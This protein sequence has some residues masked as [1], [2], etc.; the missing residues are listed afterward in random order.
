MEVC[1]HSL[2]T[3]AIGVVSSQVH[4][5]T[6]LTPG[7][8]SPLYTEQKDG[9][10]QERHKTVLQHTRR[11]TQQVLKQHTSCIYI[12]ILALRS[13]AGHGLL[14]LEVSTSHTMTHHSRQ[15][16]SGRVISS[17]QR[18]LPDN[19]QHSQETNIHA[20]GGI[21]THDL[22]RLAAADLRLRPRGHWGRHLINICIAKETR[23]N[24]EMGL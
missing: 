6:A 16:S 7:T 1:F 17:S 23:D 14:I 19:T 12:Y 8:V 18:P 15:D 5:P 4:A 21:R 10:A 24:I 20:T 2:L 11:V 22:N 3:P 9:W 13:N